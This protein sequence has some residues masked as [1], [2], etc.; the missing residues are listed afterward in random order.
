VIEA[1]EAIRVHGV[2]MGV[3]T[4][5]GTAMAL[6]GIELLGLERFLSVLVTADDVPLHKP[7][8]YPVRH[9]AQELQVDPAR[10]AY[11][12]DS[13]ADIAAARGA[14]AVAIGATWGVSARERLEAAGP[15]FMLDDISQVPD[16]LFGSA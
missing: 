9:A 8:P 6:K 16:L 1:L 11:I 13:P 12:G 2:P 10:V 15:D 5:K 4:S 14:G 3:V 7:D